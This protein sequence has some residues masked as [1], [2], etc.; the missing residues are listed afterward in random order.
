MCF[1]VWWHWLY[2]TLIDVPGAADDEDHSLVPSD[3]SGDS[4]A[5]FKLN[6]E[7]GQQTADSCLQSARPRTVPS[8]GPSSHIS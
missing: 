8:A 3:E 7:R 2:D 1:P 6:N 4:D 5:E